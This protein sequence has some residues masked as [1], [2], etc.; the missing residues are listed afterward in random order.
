MI[1]LQE[2]ID[3]NQ[4]LEDKLNTFESGLS[5]QQENA[6][7]E[8]KRINE[9]FYDEFFKLL[10]LYKEIDKEIDKRYEPIKKESK[11]QIDGLYELVNAKS[12]EPGER[13]AKMESLANEHVETYCQMKRLDEQKERLE[14]LYLEN[15]KSLYLRENLGNILMEKMDEIVKEQHGE[16]SNCQNEINGWATIGDLFETMDE[17]KKYF[18]EG[19]WLEEAREELGT[20]ANYGID[21]FENDQVI[22][23]CNKSAN[24]N[25]V[26]HQDIA[27]EMTIR[28]QKKRYADMPESPTVEIYLKGNPDLKG[29]YL[30]KINMFERE[31]CPSMHFSDDRW[32]RGIEYIDPNLN[33]GSKMLRKG[34]I[35]W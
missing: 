21:W 30:G 13:E 24:E 18:S 4:S 27:P 1:K 19:Q 23:V 5:L 9:E 28:E 25:S 33:R 12:V 8:G 11:R 6:L 35:Q 7:K 3:N 34:S 22:F 17:I 2:G 16:Y 31:Y 20:P 26:W 29:V 15:E 32:V 10:D 14:Q